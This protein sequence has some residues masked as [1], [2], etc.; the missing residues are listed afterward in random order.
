M[1]AAND[2][3]EQVPFLD[4]KTLHDDLAPRL[5]TAI[6]EVLDA[7]QLVRGPE[8]EAFEAAFASY[9]GVN[10][11]VGVGN[12][13][14]ALTLS[15][16]ALGIGPGDEVIV[17]GQTFI[18]TWLAVSATGAV[19]VPVDVSLATG[20]IDPAAVSAAITERTAAIM[21]VHLF[22]SM[23][24]MGALRE[25]ADR[26]GLA[27]VE[28]AAQAHGAALQG[29]RA[30]A[31]GDV[32]AFSFY[33][34]KNLGALGD[35]GI[36][37]TSRPD[38]ADRIRLLGNYGSQVKYVHVE[39]GVNSRLDEVQAAVLRIKLG[40][41]D[42]WNARR[43]EIAAQYD[44]ALRHVAG[45]TLLEHEPDSEP[46]HHLYPIRVADRDALATRLAQAGIATA[47]HYP[48]V[49]S[50]CA[51]YA[52]Q[53]SATLPHSTT[54]AATELSLPIGPTLTESQVARVIEALSA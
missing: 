50:H 3:R 30:G 22:G 34:G 49:P 15:L 39:A 32:A 52:A 7:N 1:I 20:Q 29:R 12:G 53:A 23:A 40:E 16:R 18:A 27:L 17:P 38:L 14:D 41:L 13:L 10:H 25:I 46:V 42:R 36:A 47:I 48:T 35:G 43:R 51:P 21:A 33:P 19:P 6:A 8:G 28:D 24:P 45:I 54:W 5:L 4:L 11:G 31:W 26:R 2:V 37:V 9:C 44:A